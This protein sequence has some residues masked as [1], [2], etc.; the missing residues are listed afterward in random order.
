MW[1]CEN[2]GKLNEGK[3]CTSCGRSA[4]SKTED[5]QTSSS[6]D[7]G[8][9][10]RY[11]NNIYNETPGNERQSRNAKSR[12]KKAK[13][14]YIVLA[15]VFGA[16]FL[17]F[18][19]FFGYYTSAKAD[20]KSG[21]YMQAAEK[22]EHIKFFLNSRQMAKKS[23]YE[24]AVKLMEDKNYEEAIE[25]LNKVL[26]YSDS[27]DKLYECRYKLLLKYQ[28]SDDYKKAS[29]LIE[30]MGDI[31]NDDKIYE[32]ELWC[33]YS[34]AKSIMDTDIFKARELL[35]KIKDDYKP[36][37]EMILECSYKIAKQYESDGEY[38]KA[39]E[40]FENCGEYKDSGYLLNSLKAKMLDKAY[41]LYESG[42]YE[43]C[44]KLIEIGKTAPSAD[45]DKAAA[46]ELFLAYKSEK[47]SLTKDNQKLYSYLDSYT[48]A[49]KIVM[50]NEDVFYDFICGAWYENGD[51]IFEISKD[52]N[53][54]R[55]YENRI[56][57]G[58]VKYSAGRLFSSSGK[59]FLYD[60]EILGEN[61]IKADTDIDFEKHVLNRQ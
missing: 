4:E 49:R 8:V 47:A 5:T 26:D 48:E 39:Y 7:G 37:N 51:L 16:L 50:E 18:A 15:A 9:T 25:C 59:A 38:E 17:A 60:I 54:L 32:I 61:K 14:I 27:K 1:K 52:K 24:N 35:E 11:K 41:Q 10:V 57:T 23:V 45:I 55:S 6:F 2:C 28:E 53:L 19:G 56:D 12:K 30:Q 34:Y 40:E 36:A 42:E 20:L 22:F 46:Y 33:N 58:K 13:K 43:R 44:E 31:K 3:F 21:R 29:E